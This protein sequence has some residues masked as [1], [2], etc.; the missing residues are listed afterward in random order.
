MRAGFETDLKAKPDGDDAVIGMTVDLRK[1]AADDVERLDV[2]TSGHGF[3]YTIGED[4][5]AR[6]RA[7]GL[8]VALIARAAPQA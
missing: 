2:L 4:S 8:Q 5:Y 6:R 3:S 7:R 1:H